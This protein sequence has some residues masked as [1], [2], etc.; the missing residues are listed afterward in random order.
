MRL[1][2]SIVCKNSADTIGRTLDSVQGLA[3]EIVAV[4]SGS[5]DATLD[6]LREA[7]AR[8]IE[9]P[10]LGYVKTKQL[11]LDHCQGDWVLALDSDESPLPELIRSIESALTNP[12]KHTGFLVNRKVYVN[13]KPLNHAWQPEW[14]LRLV[15]RGHYRWAGLDPHDHLVPINPDGS[16]HMIQ[17]DLRHD[18]ISTWPE[19]LAKQGRHAETMAR[20]MLAE[21]RKPSRFKLLTSP[22]AAFLKQFLM[23]QAFLDG[24]PG[25]RAAHATA[26]ASRLKHQAM[27]R[28]AQTGETTQAR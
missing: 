18:S 19:F 15:L 20:S 16:V 23:R 28:L 21:G 8:V 22:A 7:G 24:I 26:R 3:D 2:V 6:M 27:F 11:A 9:S 12:G 5:T 13:D 17:G 4:D 1:S 25:L 14:R 10:W